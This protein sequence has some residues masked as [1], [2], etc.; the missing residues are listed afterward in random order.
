[1]LSIEDNS[2]WERLSPFFWVFMSSAF[3]EKGFKFRS[4][5]SW[6]GVKTAFLSVK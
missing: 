6:Q 2:F 1:V 3:R 5:W 4:F